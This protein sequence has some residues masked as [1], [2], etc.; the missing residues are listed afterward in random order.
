[1]IKTPFNSKDV[2]KKLNENGVEA[3]HLVQKYGSVYQKRFD[4]NPLFSCFESIKNCTNYLEIHDNI[5]TL[6]IS[7]NMQKREIV[8]TENRLYDVFKSMDSA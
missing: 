5:V 1:M 3:K 6:P 8:L 2:I 7:S 4:R